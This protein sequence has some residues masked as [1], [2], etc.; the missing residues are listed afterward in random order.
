MRASWYEAAIL[1]GAAFGGMG[2][3]ASAPSPLIDRGTYVS[4]TSLRSKHHEPRVRYLII[5]YTVGDDQSA[6][7]TLLGDN[8]SVHYLVFRD[9]YAG[10]RAK[11]LVHALVPED[12][13]AWQAGFPSHWGRASDLN[14]SSIGIEIVNKGPLDPDFK[15]W[16]PFPEGQMRAVLALTQ[17]IVARY[18]I[19]PNRVVGHADI[20]PQRKEDP[21]PAFPW[22]QFARAGVGAWPDAPDVATYLA[23]RDPK[24]PTDVCMLQWRLAA[25]G[26][27]VPLTGTLDEATKRV[28]Q[29]F[30]MHFRNRDYAGDAD[31][32]S[33]AIVSALLEKYVKKGAAIPDATTV[34]PC[35]QGS[36][37]QQPSEQSTGS[38]PSGRGT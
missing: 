27:D 34:I 15:T 4:D 6:L 17:D 13:R 28:L 18:Q 9:P 38:P 33:D 32:E 2:C 20:A 11:P 35:R 37:M 7:Q 16:D 29:A 5:H 22:E 31:A 26:Y 36:E 23:A 19:P 25:Y 1:F 14:D 3:R 21:G 24:A 10:G 12:E 30:Q 8:V